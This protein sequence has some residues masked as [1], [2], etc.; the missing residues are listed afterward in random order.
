MQTR[1]ERSGVYG[2]TSSV[3]KTLLF[4]C[5]CAVLMSLC[6]NTARK[7]LPKQRGNTA[8]KVLIELFQ[9]FARSSRVGLS[10]SAD[11]ETPKTAFLFCLAFL[12]APFVP[13]R[14]AGKKF[15]VATRLLSLKTVGTGVPDGPMSRCYFYRTMRL[16]SLKT[17]GTGVL[18]CPRL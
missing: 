10:P 11:G 18:D 12:F 13:K 17:V 9:K 15:Y 3:P 6:G 2:H 8:R 5:I 14:K 7:V 1:T 4:Y 16:L